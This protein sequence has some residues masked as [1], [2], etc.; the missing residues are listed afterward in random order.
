[1]AQ[2]R[3]TLWIPPDHP[4]AAQFKEAE[5]EIE[6]TLEAE[7]AKTTLVKDVLRKQEKRYAVAEARLIAVMRQY[8]AENGAGPET[9][10]GLAREPQE[11]TQ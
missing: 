7:Q 9:P 6:A 3:K 5:A 2:K 1:M 11:T 8:Q 4:L 10:V